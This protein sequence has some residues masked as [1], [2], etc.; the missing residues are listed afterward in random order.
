VEDE[1]HVD[2]VSAI[3]DAMNLRRSILVVVLLGVLAALLSVSLW[4]LNTPTRATPPGARLEAADDRTERALRILRH[5][6]TQRNAAW[7]AGDLAALA[8]LYRPG[9]AAG[10]Y[11][12]WM[13]QRY[14]DRGLVV[15][16]IRMQ[17]LSVDLT[18]W[19]SRRF[20]LVITDRLAVAEA[21]D[22]GGGRHP[23]P[24]DQASTRVVTL[25]L[26]GRRWLAA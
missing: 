14:V 22:A 24:R 23:L 18:Q 6:D 3:V 1:P 7:A 11:D 20:T 2:A 17:L 9:S 12:A 21:V 10:A 15:D 19:S 4:R 13:L 25:M 8:R 5:W 16:P 26:D